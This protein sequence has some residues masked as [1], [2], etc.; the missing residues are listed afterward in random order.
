MVGCAQSCISGH[1]S[2]S[3]HAAVSCADASLTTIGEPPPEGVYSPL[4]DASLT[5]HQ[6]GQLFATW[7]S[8]YYPTVPSVLSNYTISEIMARQLQA[9]T[10]E[11][12]SSLPSHKRLST[13]ERMSKDELK[14]TTDFGILN[15]SSEAMRLVPR[16]IFRQNVRR[17]LWEPEADPHSADGRIAFPALKVL[18]IWFSM[19]M[20]DC[21]WAA[22]VLS[23]RKNEEDRKEG[24]TKRRNVEFECVD[25]ANHFVSRS[26]LV[27]PRL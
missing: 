13:V 22:K 24:G 21:V 2:H 12:K 8:A 18:V 23:D 3:A 20:G 10:P 6:R 5:L 14:Q 11:Y 1:W 7:V 25:G 26:R 9:D 4:R 27:M 17:A 15:R 19:S 16:D